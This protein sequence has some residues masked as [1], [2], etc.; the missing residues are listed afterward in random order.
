MSS[1]KLGIQTTKTVSKVLENLHKANAG[2]V[3]MDSFLACALQMLFQGNTQVTTNILARLG[4]NAE[5]MHQFLERQKSVLNQVGKTYTSEDALKFLNNALLQASGEQIIGVL[6]FLQVCLNI[7]KNL[8]QEL[9]KLGLDQHLLDME[10]FGS[11][12]T[13][14]HE[15]KPSFESQEHIASLDKLV[16]TLHPQIVDRAFGR[17]P[18]KQ[19]MLKCLIR[20]RKNNIFLVGEPGVGKT[21]LVGELV[22]ELATKQ[23]LHPSLLGTLVLQLNVSAIAADEGPQQSPIAKISRVFKAMIAAKGRFILFIDEF[24]GLIH[25]PVVGQQITD[26]LKTNLL[27]PYVRVIAATTHKEYTKFVEGDAAVTRR[28]TKIVVE[29]PSPSMAKKMLKSAKRK[30]EIHYGLTIPE[31]VLDETISLAKDY[32]FELNLPDSALELLD[33]A[34]AETIIIGEQGGKLALKTVQDVL[35]KRTG[36]PVSGRSEN[37]SKLRYIEEKLKKD[38]LFQDAAIASLIK[39]LKKNYF[40][41]KSNN[42]PIGSFLFLGSTGVGKTQLAKSL[43]LGLF[44]NKKSF[45]RFD[46]SE[47]SQPHQVARLIGSPPGYVAFDEGGLLTNYVRRNPYS[48]I[49]F[50]EL[51][52]GHPDVFN[53]FL[54]ILDDGRLTDGKGNEVSF[55]NCLIVFTSNIKLENPNSNENIGFKR[56]LTARQHNTRSLLCKHLK[57]ELVNRFDQILTFNDLT[58]SNLKEI[59]RHKLDL[60][61]SEFEMKNIS[62]CFSKGVSTYIFEHLDNKKMGARPIERAIADTVEDLILDV[63]IESNFLHTKIHVSTN[64]NKLAIK[65]EKNVQ[66]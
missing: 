12:S 61:K 2:T 50:D 37:L 1:K 27:N 19:Q 3:S 36:I 5:E 54:Q 34:C 26:L 13:N 53:I 22:V 14:S 66:S 45:V 47:F 17:E 30:T 63:A 60:L 59:I 20:E 49:L 56:S 38:V 25:L 18:E 11:A 23:K 31:E 21:T 58:A 28:F 15:R 55:K 8:S 44:N 48:L 52:K 41:I 4:I 65:V 32:L 16:S 51:E 9:S 39:R 6:E 43:N 29:E 24:H 62:V 42:R 57:P 46:M 40:G 35:L 7:G 10:L 33:E 64:G